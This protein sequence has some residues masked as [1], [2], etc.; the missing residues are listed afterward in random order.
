MTRFTPATP[1]WGNSRIT[2]RD[3]GS[4]AA[5]KQTLEGVFRRLLRSL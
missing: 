5:G 2:A 4:H 1:I 3:H